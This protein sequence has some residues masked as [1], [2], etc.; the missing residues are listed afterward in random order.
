MVNSIFS[1]VKFLLSLAIA[2][3]T[4]AGFLIF[5]GYFSFD[6]V[7]PVAGVFLLSCGA[8]AL[9]QYQERNMDARMERTRNRPLPSGRLSPVVAIMVVFITAI[10]GTVILGISG[11]WFAALLGVLNL[12]WYNGV[13]TPLKRRSYAAVVA[14]AINGAVPPVIGWVAAGGQIWDPK[15]LFIAFFIFIW[16][17]PHFWL[18]LMQYGEDY[19]KAGFYS[20]TIHFSPGSMQRIILA[21]VVATSVSTLFLPFFGIVRSVPVIILLI[22]ANCLLLAL[23]FIIFSTR[24]SQPDYRL[25]FMGFNIFMVLVFAVLIAEALI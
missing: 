18:L 12:A 11:G 23:F 9:N 1:L 17:I 20:I 13:Y 22:T 15:I 5:R 24:K 14:G 7:F 2:F 25:A 10:S 8:A 19:K 16:Q 3:S 21:W 6:S 4:L